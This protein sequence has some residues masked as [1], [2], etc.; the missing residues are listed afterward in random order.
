MSRRILE[1]AGRTDTF[2]RKVVG[3]LESLGGREDKRLK[4]ILFAGGLSPSHHLCPYPHAGPEF[5][6]LPGKKMVWLS[7]PFLQP[8]G[9]WTQNRWIHYAIPEEEKPTSG[10]KIDSTP[11]LPPIRRYRKRK[12]NQPLEGGEIQLQP[13]PQLGDTGRG[14]ETNLWKEDRFNSRPPPN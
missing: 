9:L 8:Q 10:R 6:P 13:S 1:R 4:K 7:Q 14:R 2:L 11:A 5:R 3:R 12:R